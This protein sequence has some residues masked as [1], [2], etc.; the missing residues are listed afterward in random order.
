MTKRSSNGRQ[1]VAEVKNM[2]KIILTFIVILFFIG[3]T[4]TYHQEKLTST[5]ER[6]MTVGIVQK[7]IRVGMSQT[8]VVEALGSPNIITRDINQKE[9]WV[10]DKIASEASYSNSNVGG[11]AG[12]AGTTGNTLLL[13]LITGRYESGASST[14]Q[15][16]LT[17]VIKFDKDHLVESFSYHS[18]KF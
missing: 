1:L 2:K 10:Y 17:V 12:G 5:K 16:T 14:T 3:C 6:E 18:S 9:A 8:E 13:G 7:E 11:V 4:P 15:K